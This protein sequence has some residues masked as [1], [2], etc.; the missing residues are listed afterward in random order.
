MNWPPPAPKSVAL[1]G[2]LAYL[3]TLQQRDLPRAAACSGHS[4]GAR[5]IRG[6]VGGN[7][8]VSQRLGLIPRVH[9]A[10]PGRVGVAAARRRE[11]DEVDDLLEDVSSRFIEAV[12]DEP[13]RV[14]V[15]EV[16]DGLSVDFDAHHT[17][18]V[19]RGA[20]PA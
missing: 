11:L 5:R 18:P 15:D 19:T 17:T 8:A 16:L 20:C 3:Q 10:E 14:A 7:R 13:L 1:L 9:P 2:G 12:A 6:L 4:Q